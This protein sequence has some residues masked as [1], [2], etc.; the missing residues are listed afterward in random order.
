MA[1]AEAHGG[2]IEALLIEVDG[3]RFALPT[4]SVEEVIAAAQPMPLPEAPP[5]VLGILNV[6]GEVLPV[7]DLRRHLGRPS[8]EVRA[9]D[10]LILAR[11]GA[12]RVLLRVDRAID[13][14]GI[15]PTRLRP[16]EGK[17]RPVASVLALDDGA[18]LVQDAE[19]FLDAE[20]GRALDQALR[21]LRSSDA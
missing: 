2:L 5:F 15:D 7:L 8:R 16:L 6:R 1:R 4:H 3:V 12:R 17:H 9:S 11:T 13:L 20:E 21:Q 18:L 19:L 10:H 14:Y